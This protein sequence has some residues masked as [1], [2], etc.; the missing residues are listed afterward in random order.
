MKGFLQRLA[1]QAVQP[2][3]SI[4]NRARLSMPGG[5]S[6]PAVP[7][8]GSDEQV[9]PPAV[10]RQ[11][12]APTPAR[13]EVGEKIH[14]QIVPGDRT[15]KPLEAGEEKP[16]DRNG[17]PASLFAANIPET[18][19]RPGAPA[20][21]RIEETRTP[22]FLEEEP[23]SK[24]EPAG[25]EA[26]QLPE[27]LVAPETARAQIEKENR[28][29]ALRPLPLAPAPRPQAAP[30]PEAESDT[31]HVEIGRIELSLTAPPAPARRPSPPPARKTLSLDS[32]L[33]R[34]RGQL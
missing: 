29:A 10:D 15:P 32:Y 30:V 33:Q 9:S 24:I 4:H 11:T 18:I 3:P 31:V 5:P 28:T 22:G 8:L 2:A 27:P 1:A 17:E 19:L 20:A 34:R 21:M 13:R 7:G 23:V 12:P 25:R 16:R 14:R 6:F 26:V